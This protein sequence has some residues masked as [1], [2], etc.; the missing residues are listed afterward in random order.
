MWTKSHAAIN[1]VHCI[2]RY[3]YTSVYSLST[4]SAF[5]SFMV[6]HGKADGTITFISER[7]EDEPADEL[8]PEKT[9]DLML[10]YVAE[11]T[12]N[13]LNS[14]NAHGSIGKHFPNKKS[15]AGFFYR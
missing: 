2:F 13:K 15:A 3:H 6:G 4:I 14:E 5:L 8:S 1:S 12:V 9:I 10:A 7:C 11:H